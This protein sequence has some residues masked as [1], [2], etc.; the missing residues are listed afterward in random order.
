MNELKFKG[1]SIVTGVMV[2][3]G[4]I[5]TERDTPIIICNGKREYVKSGTV[6]QFT[7]A[8]DGNSNE[9]YINDICHVDGLGYCVVKVCPF[10]GVIFDD[11]KGQEIPIIDCMAEN[12]SFTIIG[13]AHQ[14]PELL[15]GTKS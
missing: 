5:D 7:G 8:Y 14:N 11:Q 3:G 12:D 10:Y 1:L 4:G 6:A 13:N 2:F 15:K 9:M